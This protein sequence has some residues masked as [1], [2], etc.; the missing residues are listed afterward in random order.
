MHWVE[1]QDQD[2]N[3]LEVNLDQARLIKP[4]PY[5]KDAKTKLIT[6]FFDDNSFIVVK[7][8]TPKQLLNAPRSNGNEDKF[9]RR[10][11]PNMFRRKVY[12]SPWEREDEPDINIEAPNNIVQHEGV[13]YSEIMN[14]D[15][16]KSKDVPNNSGM[17]DKWNR[18]QQTIKCISDDIV[19]ALFNCNGV[20]HNMLFVRN[21]DGEDYIGSKY[22]VNLILRGVLQR[23]IK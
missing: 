13:D 10:R 23:H 11:G 7:F 16:G 4:G 5:D 22:V 19:K 2:N 20:D 21:R 3:L 6:L 12:P 15:A 17:H 14:S 9:F 18:K 1:I 8:M